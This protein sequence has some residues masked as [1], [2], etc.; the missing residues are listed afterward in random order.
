LKEKQYKV[1]HDDFLT[2]EKEMSFDFIIMNPPFSN[3]DDHFIKAWEI[4]DNTTIVCLL[5]SET[6]NNPYSEKRKL[7]K[8]II[9]DNQ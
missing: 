9:D 3:G 7:V 6:I 8:K 4:A 1:V 2:Y 5:N